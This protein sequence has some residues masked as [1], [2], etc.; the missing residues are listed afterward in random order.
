MQSNNFVSQL[1]GL[2]V[3][4]L[5]LLCLGAFAQNNAYYHLITGSFTK[6]EDAR[7]LV[8]DLKEQGYNPVILFPS[9]DNTH[10]RVSIYQ[11][12]DK[13]E[14]NQFNASQK[15]Q[16]KPSGW[17]LTVNDAAASSSSETARLARGDNTTNPTQPVSFH[18]IVGSFDDFA[19]ADG[20]VMALAQ[21]GYEPYVIFP[22][23]PGEKYRV[24]VYNADNRKEIEAYSA[25]MKKRGKEK[26]W[27][28]EETDPAPNTLANARMASNSGTELAD[29]HLIGGS[30]Q[31]YDQAINFAEKMEG[32]G[33]TAIVLF[34]S[35]T[36]SDRFRVSIYQADNQRA[37]VRY[38]KQLE[39]GGKE[40]GWIYAHQ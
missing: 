9:G 6:L 1:R 30:F 37:V 25:L 31:T 36:H 21:Q 5:L 12:F 34:P 16:K 4:A 32:E 17:V 19:T 15:A 26:G 24:S 13:A 23:N 22:K 7:T 14:V 27:I 38:R 2:F 3:I 10:Y 8:N 39:K 28:Y 29:F 11:A 35:V 18:L 40:A 20:L 33:H